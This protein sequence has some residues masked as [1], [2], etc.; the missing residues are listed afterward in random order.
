MV[1]QSDCYEYVNLHTHV[2]TLSK[3]IYNELYNSLIWIKK[4]NFIYNRFP[5]EFKENYL[6]SYTSSRIGYI[7]IIQMSIYNLSI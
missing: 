1:Y 7:I 4:D 6:K 5:H 2:S 3:V